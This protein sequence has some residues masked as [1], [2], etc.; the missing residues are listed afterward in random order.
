MFAP[1]KTDR[2]MTDSAIDTTYQLATTTAALLGTYLVLFYP[3]LRP[4]IVQR[5]PAFA[6]PVWENLFLP[7]VLYRCLELSALMATPTVGAMTPLIVVVGYLCYL[8]SF[9]CMHDY[10]MSS[11]VEEEDNDSSSD[12]TSGS[13]EESSLTIEPPELAAASEENPDNEDVAID[14]SQIT[15]VEGQN[16]EDVFT[17]LA[18]SQVTEQQDI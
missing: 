16:P 7:L 15:T 12:E 17:V 2:A 9:G 14:I 3:A 4:Y 5:V 13:S 11:K 6:T 1:F 8:Y 18:A 10:I